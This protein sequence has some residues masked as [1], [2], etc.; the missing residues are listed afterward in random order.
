MRRFLVPA[1][2]LALL[3]VLAARTAMAQDATPSA[4]QAADWPLDLAAMVL[5]PADLD[6]LGL[7]GF[8][9]NDS[10]L[11]DGQ[12]QAVLHAKRGET[13]A[14]ERLALFQDTGFRHR[15]FLDMGRPR[16]P[17]ERI[18]G[19]SQND[20]GIWTSIT[21]FATTEGAAAAFPIIEDERGNPN[22]RDVPGTHPIG[23]QSELTRHN[24][25][26][27][28]GGNP[29]H[30]LNLTFRVGNLIA[31]VGIDDYTAAESEVATAEALAEAL[32]RKMER[33]RAGE[34]AEPGLGWRVLRLEP[35]PERIY[36]EVGF[37]WYTR[38]HRERPPMWA[39]S[40]FWSNS[41]KSRSLT[42]QSR[43]PPTPGSWRWMKPM[44]TSVGTTA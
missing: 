19:T 42:T 17:V 38:L 8:G 28:D 21:E 12:T 29:Y 1:S 37:D 15:Y 14:S 35:D 33:V 24:E 31:D 36:R 13:G 40:G 34:L 41:A 23:D 6:A 32:R 10:S 2:V 16:V 9:L 22:A 26:T 44:S 25:V 11:R 39:T 4:M 3:A 5:S 27:I 43:A 30:A 20:I 18:H 7:P